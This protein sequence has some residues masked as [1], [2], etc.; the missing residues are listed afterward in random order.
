VIVLEEK[1]HINGCMVSC[2]GFVQNLIKRAVVKRKE[3]DDERAQEEEESGVKLQDIP[4]EDKL[5]PGGLDPVEGFESL[6]VILHEAFECRRHDIKK[7]LSFGRQ[8]LPT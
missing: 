1:E 4:I 6:P 2:D 5:G 8:M 3:I 7:C